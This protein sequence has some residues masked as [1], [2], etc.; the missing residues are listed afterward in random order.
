METLVPRLTYLL[1]L[2][3]TVGPQTAWGQSV[4]ETVH[5]EQRSFRLQDPPRYQTDNPYPSLPR[6]VRDEPGTQGWLMS[7]DQSIELAL[8]NAEAIRISTGPTVTSTGRTIY[9][10]AISNTRIDSERGRFDPVF[11]VDNTFQH[12]EIPTAGI[13]NPNPFQDSLQGFQTDIYRLE[14]GL[15]K[16]NV[17]GGVAAFEVG[18]VYRRTEPQAGRLDPASRPSITLSYVQP[19]LQGFGPTA[20]L[21]PIYI[22]RLDTNRS[23]FQLR[24]SVQDLVYSVIEN[25]W[26]LVAARVDTWAR[27]QQVEQ[28]RFAFERALARKERGL[29]DSGEVTQTKLAYY[30]FRALLISSRSNLLDRENTLRNLLF[31]P[32]AGSVEIKPTTIPHLDR[33][34]FDW[35]LLI[36]LADSHRPELQDLRTVL[37]Q[38]MH[39]LDVVNN[40]NQAQLNAVAQY[41][42]H[43]L[44]GKL[45]PFG[46]GPPEDYAVSGQSYTDW[47][48]GLEYE[49]PLGRRDFRSQVRAQELTY[50]R[51][52]ALLKQGRHAAFQQL[53]S[54][55]R[56]VERTYQ[57]Y[58]AYRETRLAAAENLQQQRVEFEAGRTIFLNVL[59]AIT[60]WGNAVSAEVSSLMRYNIALA[61]VERQTGTILQTHGI[62][63][64]EEKF[65]AEG[66]LGEHFAP[67][68]YPRDLRPST[69]CPRY[70]SGLQPLEDQYLEKN[71]P[72]VESL[73]RSSELPQPLPPMPA[74][75]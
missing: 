13:S 3:L 48:L 38:D 58:E 36:N 33:V 15:Q 62:Q 40:Q 68:C 6:T 4:R 42:W 2:L 28:G 47:I 17:L 50:A 75:P 12:L 51:D 16:A 24:G 34:P 60:D 55:Y 69:N 61:N 29:A 45:T 14:A 74:M 20:N 53:A 49:V 9:D 73:N 23:Y 1:A 63:F 31:L 21:A 57:E 5:P 22:A 19:L 37:W 39:R 54:T 35:D 70:E 66:P 64:L 72:A 65:A 59:A 44:S 41:K 25:Y 56:D 7:L 71:T 18:E 27:E 8:L 10:A 43:G 30:N 26:L 11:S 67:V 46:G 32:P 52:L